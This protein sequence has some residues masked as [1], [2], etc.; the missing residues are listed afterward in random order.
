M[1]AEAET[2]HGRLGA[3]LAARQG[4]GHASGQHKKIKPPREA[5]C[6]FRYGDFCAPD[7][8]MICG[9]AHDDLWLSHVFR[10]KIF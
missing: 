10:I 9:G 8:R 6:D 1:G 7:I 3:P 2:D 5:L 4:A